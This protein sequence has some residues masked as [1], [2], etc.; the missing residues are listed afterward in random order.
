MKY[1]HTRSSSQ[2]LKLRGNKQKNQ[3]MVSH[4][5]VFS[6]SY[7]TILTTTNIAG[8]FGYLYL[9]IAYIVYDR[10]FR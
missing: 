6:S 2:V 9:L 3:R 4:E 8:D 5:Q 1:I 10:H 7:P